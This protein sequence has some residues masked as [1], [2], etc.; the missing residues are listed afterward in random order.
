ML[1][2]FSAGGQVRD[3][4]DTMARFAAIHYDNVLQQFVFSAARWYNPVSSYICQ[5][6]Q[7][8]TDTFYDVPLSA[9]VINAC[10]VFKNVKF[11]FFLP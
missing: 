10:N 1:T 3:Q 7:G 2:L 8:L 6:Q 4:R 9:C 5:L 11:I